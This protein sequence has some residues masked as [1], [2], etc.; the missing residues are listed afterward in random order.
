MA[1]IIEEMND[2]IAGIFPDATIRGALLNSKDGCKKN[3]DKEYFFVTDV[4]NPLSACLKNLYPDKFEPTLE[5]KKIFSLG[6]KIHGVMGK[7]VEEL[8]DFVDTEANLDGGLMG[9]SVRG[10]M[11][12]ETNNSIFE[13]KSKSELPENV[14]DVLKKYPQDVEQLAFYSVLDSLKRRENYL[15][16]IS[17]DGGYE[18]KVFKI[19]TKDFEVVE[20]KLR[21][22]VSNLKKV[23]S[24][25]ESLSLFSKCRYCNPDCELMKEGSCEYFSN[26]ELECVVKDDVEIFRD[27]EMENKMSALVSPDKFEDFF[28]VFNIITSRKTLHKSTAELDDSFEMDKNRIL[29]QAYF[30]NVFF[31]SGLFISGGEYKEI[32]KGNKIPEV[33]LKKN[34]FIKIGEKCYPC[35][36]QVSDSSYEP[37]LRHPS[38]YKTGELA[39]LSF[40]SGFDKGYILTYFP[41]MNDD[42][43][44]FEVKFNFGEGV[45][46][47]LK[48]IVDILK[49]KDKSK[50]S[51]LPECPSFMHEK[52]VYREICG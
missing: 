42:V 49:S 19:I 37:M 15:I 30:E 10:R 20:K 47:K 38:S 52:C 2:C 44:V 48:N 32:L 26:S 43:R 36:I 5:A 27:V 25:E 28:S 17:Q 34:N 22:R 16:F 14:S 21:E 4:C 31:K 8:E 24:G 35:L 40:L 7:A 29:N 41:K 23:F 13:F 50:I 33:Y 9:I 18:L 51:L 11:D 1:D 3:T 45:F 39:I 12:A 6:N 46:E